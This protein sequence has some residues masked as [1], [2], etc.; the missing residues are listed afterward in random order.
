MRIYLD[1]DGVLCDFVGAAC[2]LHGRDPAT[3]T[4]WNFF[5]D[6]GMT[7]EEFWRP[8]HEAGEDFWANLE[9]YP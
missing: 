2:K 4:H 3:V 6:W 7:A 8:I 5:K 9:P 1:M